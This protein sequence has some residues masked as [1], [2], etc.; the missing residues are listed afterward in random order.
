MYELGNTFPLFSKKGSNTQN[1]NTNFPRAEDR[2]GWWK[3]FL[4][5][6]GKSSDF[7]AHIRRFIST[8]ISRTTAFISN[9]AISDNLVFQFGQ[10]PYWIR[11][12]HNL[13]IVKW[14][15]IIVQAKCRHVWLLLL[16]NRQ[17]PTDL[18]FPSTNYYLHKVPPG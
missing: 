15:K 8:S 1:C 6:K 14:V 18:L 13:N 17:N 3:S 7:A 16:V 11:H 12:T 9:K 10:L 2:L 5:K 4:F